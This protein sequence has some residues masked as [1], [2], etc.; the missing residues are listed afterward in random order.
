MELK[1]KFDLYDDIKI[2]PFE[3]LSGKVIGI[4]VFGKRIKIF[5]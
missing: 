2:I 5:S 4:W 1:T 3:E